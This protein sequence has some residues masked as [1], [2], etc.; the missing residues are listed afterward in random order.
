MSN[1]YNRVVQTPAEKKAKQQADN[2]AAFQQALDAPADSTF[3]QSD[4]VK[5]EFQEGSV[6]VGTS[7]YIMP[8]TSAGTVRSL[9]GSGRRVSA[10]GFRE[11]L[12]PEQ[13]DQFLM[14]F[15]VEPR[16]PDL[17]SPFS[18]EPPEEETPWYK[19]LPHVPG[20]SP[21]G[22]TVRGWGGATLGAIEKYL[23]EPAG[24]IGTVLEA[25]SA[26]GLIGKHTPLSIPGFQDEFAFNP[27]QLPG[28]EDWREKYK[29]NIPLGS[30]LATELVLDPIN[31]I[32]FGAV[33]KG[34]KQLAKAGKG[35]VAAD[36][37]KQSENARNL[38]DPNSLFY[39]H[40]ATNL[41]EGQQQVIIV[42]NTYPQ[43]RRI[44]VSKDFGTNALKLAKEGEA[45]GGYKILAGDASRAE[46][47]KASGALLP[48]TSRALPGP[49][50]RGMGTRA[51]EVVRTGRGNISPR[52]IVDDVAA[53]ASKE[54]S[55]AEKAEFLTSYRNLMPNEVSYLDEVG[56]VLPVT[57]KVTPNPRGVRVPPKMQKV[58]PV[59][60][61]VAAPA[62]F[63][64]AFGNSQLYNVI[65]GDS[66]G[67][68]VVAQ[69]LIGSSGSS[70]TKRFG[71]QGAEVKGFWPTVE[72]AGPGMF[73]TAGIQSIVRQLGNHNPNLENLTFAGNLDVRP[74]MNA[75]EFVGTAIEAEARLLSESDIATGF[76]HS[77]DEIFP[78]MSSLDATSMQFD[79]Y[80]YGGLNINRVDIDGMPKTA[81]DL[82]T[83]AQA[84]TPSSPENL[85]AV[86]ANTGPRVPGE[87]LFS[88]TDDISAYSYLYAKAGA[89]LSQA[90]RLPGVRWTAGLWNRAQTLA[91][92][93]QLGKLG[94]D[95]DVY[96]SVEH[97][98]VR[99]QVMAW[100]S[101]AQVSL[102]FK[103]MDANILMN[104][105]GTWRAQGVTGYDS[106]KATR[107]SAHGTIDDILKDAQEVKKGNRVQVN[108]G[109]AVPA[110][111]EK[112][113]YFLTSEQQRYI[114]DALEMME[115]SW[116]KNNNAGVDVKRIGEEYWHRILRRGPADKAENFFNSQWAKLTGNR[117]TGTAI[118]KAYQKERMFEDFDDAI[119]AGYVYDTNPATRLAAR[120]DAGIETFADQNAVNRLLE[121]KNADG[122]SMFLSR[123]AALAIRT[124]KLGTAQGEELALNLKALNT[125]VD[126]AR[127]AKHAARR[128]WKKDDTVAN[129]EAYREAIAAHGEALD[130]LGNAKKL[131][132]PGLYQAYLQSHLVDSITRDEI[133]KKVY[134]P[135]VQKARNMVNKDGP[136][137]GNIG[138]KAQDI[139]QLFR[140]LMT[141]LDLA[142]MG[143]QGNV[144]AF[145]DFRSWTT[146]V[147]ES[148]GA[149]AR[150]PLAYVEKNRAIMEEGQQMGAIMRPTEFLFKAN[151][152]S[153]SPTKLPLLGPAFNGFQRSFE[154]FIV[155]GQTEFYKTMRT[156]V[157]PGERAW[158]PLGGERLGKITPSRLKRTDPI[159]EFTPIATDEARQAMVEYGRVI[160]N[161]MGT[162][163]YAILGIRPTQQAIEATF[164][165]AARFMRANMGLIGSAMRFGRG[166][167]SRA[168]TQ[169]MMHMLAGGI[170]ITNAIHLAQTGRPVNMTD[171]FAPDWMQVSI[172]KTYFNA[173][174]PL[175][176]YFRTIAR[177]TNIMIDTQDTGK[178][179]TEIKN[180]LTS[181]AGLPI[182]AMQIGVAEAGG[183]GARTFEGEEI[184]WDNPE[185]AFRSVG[186]VLGE[187][188]MPI[189]VSGI[190]E[191]IGDGRW[192]GTVTEVFG[193][194]GRAS[195]YSQMDIMFQRLMADPKNPMHIQ[196]LKEG[197]ETTGA[198]KYASDYEKDWMQEQFGELH[199]RMVQGARGPYGDAGR[200]WAEL[201]TIAMTGEDGTGGMIGL[202]E[203]LYQPVQSWASPE[204]IKSGDVRPVDGAEYRRQLNEI[205]NARWIG[206]QTVANTYDLFQDERD[207]PTDE[208]ERALYDYRE[209][210]KANTDYSVTPP[211][212]NWNMLDDAQS[213]F[214]KGLSPEILTY[215]HQQSGLNRD[216]TALE[217]FNDK[218]MLRKY[219][220]KK[221]EISEAMPPEF[222]HVHK[223]W[224]AMSDME[225]E[226]YVYSPQV[227]TAME[228]INRQTKIWLVE[229]HE[230]GDSRAEEFEKKLVKWGYE[231]SPVTPAGQDLQRH[232]LSKL[233]TEEH[234]KLPFARNVPSMPS[235]PAASP[236][237]DD[238]GV[239]TPNW[240]QQVLSAR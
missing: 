146:A 123:E 145:R 66:A 42:S 57:R 234:M 119:K 149:I 37:I 96:K 59:I 106:S 165:F 158:S 78:R 67:Q 47:I 153:A 34:A 216:E 103:E 115:D 226:K 200:E 108:E 141:N 155:V 164:A 179:V 113:I 133:F 212:I 174:G 161:L 22:S 60:K 55:A 128:K 167:Q 121:M 49:Q 184:D 237:A 101:K 238:S 98:R 99:T 169:A 230:A 225:R 171:P 235:Q 142:A 25:P 178:A 63:D 134:I 124:R 19:D 95:V 198:Y 217:L 148:I 35:A 105:Q 156:R 87:P 147:Y 24:A 143:I 88:M 228:Y 100:W 109:Q 48:D 196:R 176:T 189:G 175:Y 199:D 127:K 223:T 130:N 85:A 168:A 137:L 68:E 28:R 31:V 20:L 207:V 93:D 229:M 201:D 136:N 44:T 39:R 173:F 102:G 56:Q 151:S 239:S 10:E 6:G 46:V 12:T 135:Q 51:M 150:E 185:S 50:A 132:H 32:P 170:G 80:A 79:D 205:M 52:L 152:L 213:D 14:P 71:M 233:G 89:V 122:T 203:K 222:Q 5:M 7:G 75:Q 215:V 181:R 232:L 36:L 240:M 2:F 204:Q 138:M 139:F 211:Q 107:G 186:L 140:A 27:E 82:L 202:R 180:F 54:I 154:W 70:V 61:A 129:H 131:K 227:R 126:D 224:R 97:A 197:R 114:D 218:K 236:V 172:N 192:E 11:A 193:M 69:I 30:R 84:V 209:L 188:A 190:A 177:V 18:L 220:D 86:M 64:D 118:T 231:T 73:S 94:I 160:R 206:N 83:D 112:Q 53:F 40:V 159:P 29:E 120:L 117:P 13:H 183:T 214:E 23:A 110:G 163:D 62:G 76:A 65:D 41:E 219:W 157:M 221:D 38:E 144:L 91:P 195:P 92:D 16:A 194:T 125:A 17:F 15:S 9:D 111:K 182:R 4:L 33:V 81:S 104:R 77:I 116:R 162:E 74:R 208:Y 1:P 58:G 26:L 21:V 3:D 187:F 166:R 191:A 45:E 210:F 8:G 72:G 90:S 43:G